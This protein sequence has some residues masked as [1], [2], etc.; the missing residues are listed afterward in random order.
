MDAWLGGAR[1]CNPG[2]L[3]AIKVVEATHM[4]WRTSNSCFRL[5]LKNEALVSLGHQLGSISLMN[6]DKCAV[7]QL[8]PLDCTVRD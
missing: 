6:L 2:T 4:R 1:R 5:D 3:N 7:P 8:Y